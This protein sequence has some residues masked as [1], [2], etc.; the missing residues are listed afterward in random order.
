MVSLDCE[1][2][3]TVEAYTHTL[4]FGA[5]HKVRRGGGKAPLLHF[6]RQYRALS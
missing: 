5:V 1:V 2:V 3:E 4:F 6:A